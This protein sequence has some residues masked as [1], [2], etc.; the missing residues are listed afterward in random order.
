MIKIIEDLQNDK[1]KN[2]NKNINTVI[3]RLKTIQENLQFTTKKYDL[4]TLHDILCQ[5]YDEIGDF[6]IS[7]YDKDN[8]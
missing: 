6:N 8:V 3:C 7:V 1:M 5:I 4:E 2:I